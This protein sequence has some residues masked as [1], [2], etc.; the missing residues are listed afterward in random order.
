MIGRGG[1]AGL[2]AGAVA[3]AAVLAG[4]AVGPNFHRPAPPDV[5]GYLPG[6]LPA[7]TVAAPVPGGASQAF[8]AGLDLPGDWWTLFHSPQIAALVTRALAANSDLEAAR[9]ALRA[10]HEAELA[11][12]GALLPSVD[13]S[14]DVTRE[15]SSGALSPPLS[16]NENLFTLHTVTLN[17]AYALDVFGGI[18]RQIES[19][20]AQAEA[21][22]WQTQAAYLTLTS[23]VVSAAIQQAS[24]TEQVAANRRLVQ[25]ATDVLAILR[26]QKALGQV[27]GIDVAAQETV[28]AQAQQALPPL[29]KQLATTRDQLAYLT[30]RYP[31]QATDPPVELAALTLPAQIPVSLPSKLVDQRPDVRAAEANLHAANAQVGVAI[32]NRLPDI[33]LGAQGGGAATTLGSLLTS[34]NTFWTLAGNVAQPIFEGGTLLHKQ[35]QARALLDEARAQYRSAVLGAFQNVA[36]SLQA[37]DADGRALAASTRAEIAAQT[38]LTIT[39]RQL[40]VGQVSGVS[41]L[42][43]QQLYEQALIAR[44]QAQG[45]RYTDTVALYQSLGGGWW[46]RKSI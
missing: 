14:Y 13:A 32:A 17:V 42:L 5:G 16:V 25:I 24:L 46:N 28:L 38:A 43:A 30:G 27:T 12:R 2:A 19:T 9:A 18:R 3:M 7:A 37:I 15:K 39:R 40:D 21:Q 29:E 34:Q 22:R 26:R 11:Q 41:V 10:A 4:C 8:T 36:D 31:S 1:S 33:T 44:I 35:R 6:P 23:N 20:A 45:A